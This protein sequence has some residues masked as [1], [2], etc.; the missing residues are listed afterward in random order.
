MR[1]HV[2]LATC[3]G[4]GCGRDSPC[5]GA[6]LTRANMVCDRTRQLLVAAVVA[7]HQTVRRVAC[8]PYKQIVVQ[9]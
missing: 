8:S 2:T 4:R 7:H 5:L 3:S 9:C 6:L 1:R